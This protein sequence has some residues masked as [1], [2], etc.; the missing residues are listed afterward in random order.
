MELDER[1]APP[2]CTHLAIG[3]DRVTGQCATVGGATGQLTFVDR[4]PDP[5]HDPGAPAR[6][7]VAIVPAVDGGP[8]QVD[9]AERHVTQG[10]ADMVGRHV[11]TV[12]ACRPAASWPR[13]PAR[14]QGDRRR[15]ERRVRGRDGRP[16]QAA[17]IPAILGA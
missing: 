8:R 5:G 7:A 16:W 12:T 1:L 11:P 3:H 15:D 14:T 2:A 4:R 13:P 6:M 9:T 10:E 17:P